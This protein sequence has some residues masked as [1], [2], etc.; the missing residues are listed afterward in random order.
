MEVELFPRNDDDWDSPDYYKALF[1]YNDTFTYY[2][3]STVD[4][5]KKPKALP[6]YSIGCHGV[7]GGVCFEF[8]SKENVIY[9]LENILNE[10]FFLEFISKY[11]HLE[12][13]IDKNVWGMN[14]L[15]YVERMDENM[16][17]FAPDPEWNE[18][19]AQPL[20]ENVGA[21]AEIIGVIGEQFN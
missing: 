20:G 9:A 7:Q 10:R 8:D 17:A 6:P 3:A 2:E 5:S 19:F 13:E 15:K 4:I 18:A 14:D 21:C 16:E 11:P 1:E 12:F